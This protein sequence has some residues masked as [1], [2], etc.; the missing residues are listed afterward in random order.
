MG[1]GPVARG[2]ESDGSDSADVEA[3]AEDLMVFDG[4]KIARQI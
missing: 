2:F 3:C 1:S 4:G